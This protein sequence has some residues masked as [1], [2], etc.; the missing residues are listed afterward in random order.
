MRIVALVDI[1]GKLGHLESIADELGKADLVLLPGDITMFGHREAAEEIVG[2]VGRYCDRILAVMGNCD[3]PEVEAYLE[4]EGMCLHRRHIVVD[5][6]TFVGLGGSLPCPIPT[7]NEWSEET[8]AEHLAAAA[9]GLPENA[10]VVLVSHQPASNTKVDLAGNDQ[11]VGS[12]AVRAF[13]EKYQPVVCFSGHIHEATGIDSIGATQLIKPG[14]FMDGGY[15]V[16]EIGPG[17]KSLEAR[18]AA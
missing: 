14:P 18:N 6:I 12:T 8:V 11:H 9:N 3:Y 5:G 16:A 17:L 13:I 10:E 7:L 4:E 2:A 1:H 15:A